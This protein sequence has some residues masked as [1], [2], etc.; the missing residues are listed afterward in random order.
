[1]INLRK[2]SNTYI[3]NES[4]TK[5]K[6]APNAIDGTKIEDGAINLTSAKVTGELP[7]NKLAII[8]DVNKIQDNLVNLAKVTDD[9]RLT[10]FV[11]G[12]EEQFVIGD[13]VTPI[14]E[15]GFS[16]VT[17]KFVP[18][19]IRIIADLKV[20][21]LSGNTGYL[22]IY[23]DN[24]VVSRLSLNSVSNSYEL[25]SGEFSVVNLAIGKHKL[26]AKMYNSLALGKVYNDYFEVYMIK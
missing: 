21:L 23:I 13:V 24:E 9:V 19:K 12:E 25:I 14:I 6:I 17:G 1:M 7:N 22:D 16:K 18:T 15:T 20:D 8:E 11:A 3:P 2:T 5:E 10:S 26:T 4:I